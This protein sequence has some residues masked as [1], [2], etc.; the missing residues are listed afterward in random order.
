MDKPIDVAITYGWN[1]VS[2]NVLRSLASKDLI[3]SVG[4]ASN[5]AMSKKSKYCKYSFSYHS[6]YKY[7]SKFIDSLKTYF[8]LVSPKVY[9][10]I[11][12]EIFVVAKY[13]N[14]LKH[15]GV[16]IPIHDFDTL[17]AVHRKDSLSD[18]ANNLNI[19]VPRTYKPRKL[20]DLKT[21]W[22]EIGRD[23]KVVI[24]M[25]NT[26]GAKGVFYASS[27]E[28]LLQQYA[29]II[30]IDNLDVDNYPLIQE[31]VCGNGYGVS[32][33]FNKGKL[34][35]KFTH[36][37]L[38]EKISTGGTSTKRVSTKNPLIETYAENILS[39]LKW[40][41][42]AMAEF[43]Y[44][45][46]EKKGWLIEI[47]PRFWGSLALP[48]QAGVDFPYLLYKMAVDGDIETVLDYKED[49]AVRWL[50]GDVLATINYM[51][52]RMSLMPIIDFFSFK[53]EKYDDL[54]KD[55]LMP[56]FYECLY[57]FN[58]FMR[59]ASTNPSEEALLNVDKI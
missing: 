22:N 9:L 58:K 19:P 34:R 4:D 17:K 33:L 13:I 47:N 35:A 43:K 41:G 20:S 40:H 8:R 49:V 6:F 50:L 42:V 45:E 21:I 30:E 2:Y 12:E 46:K 57:Y 38:R 44:N 59:T 54:F 24:K 51:K 56:F 11:H 1:R 27:Y 48:I 7:P 3:V 14:E 36:K 16:N 18:I 26:N 5:I 32:M 25:I 23:R 29:Q 53:N 10:P 39:S 37:R 52:K 15:C 31:Y 28:D 55:D